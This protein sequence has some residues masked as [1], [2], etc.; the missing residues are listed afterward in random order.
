MDIDV[1]ANS[2]FQIARAAKDAAAQ[3]L[4]GQESKPAFD[5]IEPRGDSRREVKMKTWALE[6]PTLNGCR[7]MST[8]VI[9]DQMNVKRWRHLRID[10]IEELAE[11]QRTVPA[12]KLTDDF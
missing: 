7:L 11:L 5:E 6:Q 2:C 4:G 1:I 12:M 10:L 8:V 3:V 9:E